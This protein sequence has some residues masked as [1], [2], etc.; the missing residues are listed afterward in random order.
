M[1]RRFSFRWLKPYKIYDTVKDKG[2]Y[3]LE[4]LDVSRQACTFADDRFKKFHPRQRLYLDHSPN[5]H[6]EEIPNFD[7]FLAGNSDS[8]LFDVPDDVL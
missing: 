8:D 6:L 2:T 7:D 1:S 4:E 5:L 3:M